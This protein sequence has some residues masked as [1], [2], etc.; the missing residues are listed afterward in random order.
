MDKKQLIEKAGSQVALAKLL[1]VSQA[2]ISQW[3]G[4]PEGRLWQLKAIKPEWFM[5]ES[6]STL[7]G[8]LAKS[9][10]PT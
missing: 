10:S 9:I 3:K 2:A 6:E 7:S 1:G 8:S 5:A 4:V